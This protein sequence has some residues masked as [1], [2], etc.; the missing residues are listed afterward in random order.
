MPTSLEQFSSLPGPHVGHGAELNLELDHQVRVTEQEDVKVLSHVLH[1]VVDGEIPLGLNSPDQAEAAQA[2]IGP[3]LEELDEHIE[4]NKKAPIYINPDTAELIVEATFKALETDEFE[5]HDEARLLI[6]VD[7]AQEEYVTEPHKV[8]EHDIE[9]PSGRYTRYDNSFAAQIYKARQ[10]ADARREAEMVHVPTWHTSSYQPRIKSADG[11][12]VPLHNHL[13]LLSFSE[14][15]TAKFAVESIR[16]SMS[17]IDEA[18]AAVSTGKFFESYAGLVAKIYRNMKEGAQPLQLDPKESAIVYGALK[19]LAEGTSTDK[20]FDKK[21]EEH[22]GSP[23]EYQR[24]LARYMLDA[25]DGIDFVPTAG[26]LSGQATALKLVEDSKDKSK[27][28]NRV[29]ERPLQEA[30]RIKPVAREDVP[31]FM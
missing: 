27:T 15:N 6:D 8:E 7:A 12:P 9:E 3:L 29:A 25:W 14:Q 13:E 23:I 24:Q 4:K 20:R 1:G 19:G 22:V 21:I 28:V 5:Y 18:K 16:N 10:A 2:A 17:E 26:P 11:S 30:A 31:P